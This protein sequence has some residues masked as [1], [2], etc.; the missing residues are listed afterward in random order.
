ME[1]IVHDEYIEEVNIYFSEQYAG[2]AELIAKYTDIMT[3][4]R[5]NGIKAGKTANALETFISQID[6]KISDENISSDVMSSCVSR[7]C[8]SFIDRIN[9]EDKELYD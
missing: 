4:V 7:Y 8:T 6:M 5:E 9:E 3:N 1:L 2:L